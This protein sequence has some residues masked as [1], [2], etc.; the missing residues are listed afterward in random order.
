MTTKESFPDTHRDSYSRTIF[1]FWVWLL[2]DFLLFAT[3][4]AAYI[5]LHNK[6][7]GGP[8]ARELF[9]LP[10]VLLQTTIIFLCSFTAGMAGAFTH[11]KEKKATLIWLFITF[12]L[13]LAF[14]GME[15]SEFSRLLASGNGW[16]RSAFLSAYFSLVGTHGVHVLFALLWS[17]LY[18]VPLLKGEFSHVTIRRIT[19]LRMFWQFLAIVWVFVFSIVYLLGG[20]PV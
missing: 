14:M 6:T 1:G 17:L 2:T 8:P 20:K 12:L 19:C 7:F 10:S 11:R 16:D 15:F 9:H 4:F 13:G 5:V 18:A 3:L